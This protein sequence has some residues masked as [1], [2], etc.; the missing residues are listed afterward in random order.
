MIDN[1]LDSSYFWWGGVI[2]C[3]YSAWR[4]GKHWGYPFTEV[5]LYIAFLYAIYIIIAGCFKGTFLVPNNTILIAEIVIIAALFS[6]LIIIRRKLQKIAVME[7]YEESDIRR[8]GKLKLAFSYCIATGFCLLPVLTTSWG[9]DVLPSLN[10]ED[11]SECR[12]IIEAFINAS[13]P[14]SMIMV[15]GAIFSDTFI[16]Q[17]TSDIFFYKDVADMTHFCLYLRPFHVDNSF[18]ES[19]IY[20]AFQKR[21]PIFAIGNPHTVFQPNGAYRIYVT[22]DIWQEAVDKMSSKSWVTLLRLGQTEGAKWE[23]NHVFQTNTLHKVIFITYTKA[24]YQLLAEMVLEKCQIQMP[25]L[26]IKDGE[27]T[28]LFFAREDDGTPTVVYNPIRNN[29]NVEKIISLYIDYHP[30]KKE[31]LLMCKNNKKQIWKKIFD[32]NFVPEEVW[33]SRNWGAISPL[34]NMRHWPIW[35]WGLLALA[36]VLRFMLN[37]YIPLYIFLLLSFYYGNRI[38]WMSENWDSVNLFLHRQRNENQMIL[39]S[40]LFSMIINTAYVWFYYMG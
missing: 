1:V 11:V 24:D 35:A 3:L 12:S 15:V 18:D 6:A 7:S 9:A 37:S 2:F 36:W 39:F 27:A 17:K 31:A 13:L 20:K 25:E 4:W 38:T 26:P 30:D 5:L 29:N 40:F 10:Y 22:D 32:K 16:S 28:A 14:F 23:I 21:F 8:R 34:V 33:K 19:L